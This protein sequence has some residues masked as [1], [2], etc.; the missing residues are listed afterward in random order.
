MQQ[1]QASCVRVKVNKLIKRDTRDVPDLYRHDSDEDGVFDIE[2]ID[3][4]G[5]GRTIG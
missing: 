3:R 4:D 1:G 5:D 2:G